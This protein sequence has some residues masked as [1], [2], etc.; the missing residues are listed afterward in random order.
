M[1]SFR[2]GRN[3]TDD[4]IQWDNAVAHASPQAWDYDAISSFEQ[5]T[6][7]NHDFPSSAFFI[8]PET[9]KVEM[10]QGN[11]V[12]PSTFS[13]IIPASVTGTTTKSAM[14][15]VQAVQNNTATAQNSAQLKNTRFYDFH[16]RACWDSA[17]ANAPVMKLGTIVR[18]YVPNN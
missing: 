12:Q 3:Q 1:R 18:L 15:W 4:S 17:G 11:F 9:G 6:P 5:C 16:I 7:G 14:L 8:N 13:Q 2:L 10:G